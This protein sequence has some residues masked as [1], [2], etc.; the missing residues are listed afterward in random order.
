MGD[1]M[2][3]IGEFNRMIANL[4]ELLADLESGPA[5]KRDN[6]R[7]IPERGIYVFYECGLP[8]YVGR[9]SGLRQRLLSHGQPSS[10]QNAATFA[11]ILAM[12]EATKRKLDALS[13]QRS[14]R[15]KDP[16]F[17]ELYTCAKERVSLMNIRVVEVTDPIGQTVFE[18]YAALALK[19][20]Y[21]TFENH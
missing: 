16:E 3:T 9:S 5:L 10:D 1:G 19:T 4:P 15:Q 2:K 7:R 12:E 20:R 11:F 21:N 13:L 17:R 18:P 14:I 8:V 6:L